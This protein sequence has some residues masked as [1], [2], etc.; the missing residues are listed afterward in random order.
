[1]K[2]LKSILLAASLCVAGAAWAGIIV[3]DKAK[4]EKGRT[5]E[6]RVEDG[7]VTGPKGEKISDGRY[8]FSWGASIDVKAGRALIDPNDKPGAVIGPEVKPGAS[9]G[10]IAPEFKPGVAH[11][12]ISPEDK[13]T[14]K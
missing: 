6:L 14:G 12:A 11:G 8:L 10:A 5:V 9:R 13:T 2:S 7:K 3:H 4:D 1:M